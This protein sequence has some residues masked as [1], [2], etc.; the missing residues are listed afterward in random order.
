[1]LLRVFRGDKPKNE[2]DPP[3]NLVLTGMREILSSFPIRKLSLVPAQRI[4]LSGRVTESDTGPVA[5]VTITIE[6]VGGESPLFTNQT[7]SDDPYPA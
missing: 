4:T 5:G 2:L 6:Q 7:Q 1:M 3:E